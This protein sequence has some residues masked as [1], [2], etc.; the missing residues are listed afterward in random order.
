MKKNVILLL[1]GLLFFVGILI[2]LKSNTWDLGS[3]ISMNISGSIL[4]IFSAI[5]F[6]TELYFNKNNE[7]F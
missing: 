7:H 2:I 3:D 6:L 1:W 5:G 4:S